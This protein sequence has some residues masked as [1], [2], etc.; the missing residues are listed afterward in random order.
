MQDLIVTLVQADQRWE[1]KT[2]NLNHFQE[3]IDDVQ[4]TDLIVFPE[5]FHTSFTMHVEVMGE[6]FE[7]S[8][9]IRWLQQISK[10]KNAAVYT[11]LIIHQNNE[12]QNM[13]VFVQ[14][15]GKISTYA[16]RKSFCLARED[17]Y[18]KAGQDETIVEFRGWKIQL[19]ICYDLRFPEIVRN[20]LE[21]GVP[22]YDLI[23][24]V[25]NWPEK[26][27][28]HW[29]TLLKARA[30][31]NQCYVVGVNRVGKD[32]NN[33]IYSGDSLVADPQGETIQL[34]ARKEIVK[35]VQLSS[36]VLKNTRELLPFLKDR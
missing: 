17:R 30:I 25:A 34:D 10:E 26:R 33:L 28:L 36:E 7:Q 4:N 16:K 12:Y 29:T 32:G 14:P 15:D 21:N 27:A 23:L 22:V 6:E 2:G 11:S 35:T 31:E 24:Y 1:D 3:L 5:M 19:Q 20:R 8:E 9:G 13:G 18:F